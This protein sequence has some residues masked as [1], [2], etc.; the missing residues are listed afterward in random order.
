MSVS[1]TNEQINL[2]GFNQSLELLMHKRLPQAASWVLTDLAEGIAVQQKKFAAARTEIVK[3]H[4]GI[5]N[6]RGLWGFDDKH[7]VTPEA[8]REFEE[9][10][11]QSQEIAIEPVKLPDTDTT[12][13]PID[14]EPVIFR[15]LKPAL[16]R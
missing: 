12:G 7:P 13:Q 6:E 16:R 1:F 10:M 2:P 4:G 8:E 3:N 11:A 5:R 9:L 15:H 14:Y